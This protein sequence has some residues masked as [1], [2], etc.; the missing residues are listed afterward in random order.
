M[1]SRINDHGR[2]DERNL[3]MDRAIAEKLKAD[4]GLVQ[5]A[6]STLARWR[7]NEDPPSAAFAEWERIVDSPLDQIIDIL[8]STAQHATKLRQSSP[9]APLLTQAERARI[10]ESYAARTYHQSRKRHRE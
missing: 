1:S 9:F 8:T 6:K 3:A 7:Q 10:N 4:P 2:I 5:V